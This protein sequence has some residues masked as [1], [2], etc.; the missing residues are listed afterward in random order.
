MNAENLVQQLNISHPG[1]FF[2]GGK[3]IDPRGSDSLEIVSPVSEEVIATV[4]AASETDVDSAVGAARAAFDSGE[5]P[6]LA[7]KERA[8]Y[9]TRLA[10]QLRRRQDDLAL[11]WTAQMGAPVSYAR[12]L[13]PSLVNF[14]DYYAGA[15]ESFNWIEEL[16]SSHEGQHGLLVR[17]PVGVVAAIVPWNGPFF[18]M[19]IKVAPALMAGCTV[20]IK[21]SPET[22]L[23]SQIFAECVE[24]AGLPP[25][26]VNVLP[27]DRYVSD[28]LV[29]QQGID[30][31]SFTG[32]TTAGRRVGAVCADR[33]ARVTLELGGKSAAL[34][35]EDYDV[36]EAAKVLAPTSC[37][38]SGQVCTNLTRYLVPASKHDDFVAALKG[39]MVNIT[40][41]DPS[42]EDTFMGPIAT[43]RQFER[44]QEYVRIAQEE[45]AELVTGGQRPQ[46]LERGY[47]F[48]P[49]LLV[50][51]NNQ[52]RVAQ[53][54]IF[55]P[56]IV[57]IPYQDLDDAIT[58][59]NDSDYG[60]N[61]AVFTHDVD[62]AYQIARSVRTGTVGQN[63]SKCD[64]TIS[65]GGFKQSGLGRE[66]GMEALNHFVELKTI[67]LE[68]KPSG[69]LA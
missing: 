62:K 11:A 54:E 50:N 4:P 45:G 68:G 26:V 48:E 39:E 24:A 1:K 58:M 61:G 53:E 12:A 59:A 49:T 20:V 3:W 52:S 67:I 31:V 42:A 29:R 8:A 22:P 17:E 27:A 57:V 56:V 41:G 25:G 15:A 43:K 32:S 38:N 10:E 7:P 69:L 60:L 51:V 6:R 55:G 65:F 46:G 13:T 2:I 34:I 64:F 18:T 40:V 35:L 66:G 23:E 47:Y 28:Y 21:P 33:V 5:W 36:V 14:Y 63:G 9:L 44:V 19:T 30:K 37:R 16:P